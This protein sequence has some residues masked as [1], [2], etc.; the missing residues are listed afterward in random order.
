MLGS[1][2]QS[3][4]PGMQAP[5][6]THAPAAQVTADETPGSAVQ[7]RPHAPQWFGS[8]A[9]STHAPMHIAASQLGPTSGTSVASGVVSSAVVSGVT[10]EASCLA[11]SVDPSRKAASTEPSV[12]TSRLPASLPIRGAL[13]DTT[14]A[15][16]ANKNGVQIRRVEC[17]TRLF[18]TTANQ[19][20]TG[21]HSGHNGWSVERPADARQAVDS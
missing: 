16:T 19:H 2:S 8:V 14:R 6:N 12:A 11:S 4:R 20:N 9:V 5:A 15:A 1:P 21:S 7:S 17:M 13:Q 3:A 18:I 10:S